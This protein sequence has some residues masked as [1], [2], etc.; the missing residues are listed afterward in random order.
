MSDKCIIRKDRILI[1]GA[2]FAYSPNFSGAPT[3]F[4]KNGGVRSFSIIVPKEAEATLVEQGFNL[5]KFKKNDPEDDRL[6]LTI[7]VSNMRSEPDIRLIMGNIERKL[8]WDE[9]GDLDAM[10]LEHCDL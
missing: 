3:I 8:D 4:D 9:I 2:K 1:E 6:A 10:D 5:R 7:K